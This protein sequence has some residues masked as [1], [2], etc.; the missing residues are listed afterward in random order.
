MVSFF[1]IICKL[2]FCHENYTIIVTKGGGIMS[3]IEDIKNRIIDLDDGEIIMTSDF[4]DLSSITTIRKCLGRCVDEGMIRRV[5][6]GV[7]EKPRYSKLLNEFMPTNPEKVA[8][9]L[10]R[11]YHWTIAPCG[12]IALN[13]LGLTTQVPTAWIYVSDGPYRDF[14]WG[15]I[16]LRFKHKANREISQLSMQTIL[17][18][19][20]LRALG[21]DRIDADIISQ[22]GKHFQEKD[23]DIILNEATACSEWIYEMIRKVC[24]A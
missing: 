15:N 3:I 24:A 17:V 22:L 18:I 9:A 19:E 11:N 12:D 10:A 16:K 20:A 4:A 6:D 7:Y 21:K 8:Y 1:L 23:K 5:F 2:T 14:E 13:K